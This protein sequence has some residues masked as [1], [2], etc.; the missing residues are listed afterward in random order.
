M[1]ERKMTKNQFKIITDHIWKNRKKLAKTDY[2]FDYPDYLGLPKRIANKLSPEAVDA[3][4]EIMWVIEDGYN[5]R[6]YKKLLFQSM[7]DLGE[8]MKGF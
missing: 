1:G 2:E 5:K 3:I 8:K 4:Q 7:K 6:F